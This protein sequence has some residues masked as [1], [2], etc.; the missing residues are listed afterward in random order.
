M[1]V[2]AGLLTGC[3]PGGFST[4][5]ARIGPDDGTDVCRPY[6]VAMD[7]T[8]NYFAAD[9]AKGAA[10]GALGGGLVGGLLGGDWKGAL[11][12]AGAGAVLG[13]ATSYWMALQQQAQDRAVLNTKVQSDLQQENG[14]IDRTQTAFD[15]VMDCRFRQAHDVRIDYDAHRIDH[16]TAVARMGWIKA[17]AQR[18][19]E[20]AQRIDGQIA[21]RAAQFEIAADNLQPAPSA[22]VARPVSRPATVRKAAALKLRPDAAAPEIGTLQARQPVTVG[23]LRNGYALVETQSGQKGYAAVDAIAARGLPIAQPHS[24]FDR[25]PDDVRSLAG[26]NAAR[27]DDFNQSVAVSA[28]AVSSGF[29]LAS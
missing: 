21:G 6:V 11:I 18:D 19:L 5:D 28:N 16:P 25:S 29:E 8:G 7:S 10:I 17:R 12:G 3:A 2:I 1:L 13:G 15:Q 26:S 27:R 9:I 4:Q 20:S 14:V 22:T 24:D 23:P